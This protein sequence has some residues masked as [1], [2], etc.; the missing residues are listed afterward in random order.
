MVELNRAVAI[1]MARGPA[2]ALAL[3]DQ[4]RA[5]GALNAYHLLSSVRGDLL[6]KLGRLG[7]ARREFE[8]AASLTHNER[9]RAL[10]LRRADACT[11]AKELI[12]G[13]FLLNCDTREEALDYARQCPAAEWAM[14]EVRGIGPCY[15]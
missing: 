9:E 8:Q 15:L 5:S 7:E 10:L 12:G 14:I 1:S 3:A 13:Y 6:Q 2:E 4:L 11:E